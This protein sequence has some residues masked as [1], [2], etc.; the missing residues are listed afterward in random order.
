MPNYIVLL[1][2]ENTSGMCF[3]KNLRLFVFIQ[4]DI[5]PE[6]ET[7]DISFNNGSTI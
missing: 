2:Y 5:N 3:E 4:I 7:T 6:M 1:N